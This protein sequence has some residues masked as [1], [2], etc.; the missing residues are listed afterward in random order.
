MHIADGILSL[1]VL[2]GGAVLAAAGTAY[3][4]SKIRSE[5]MPKAAC[6]SSAFFVASL[7]H[8]PIGPSSSHLIL[9]G[10]AGVILG[11]AAFPAILVALTLQAVL[12]QF[13]GFLS[14]GVNTLDMA[15]PAVVC[16]I[17][18]KSLLSRDCSQASAFAYGFG[19]GFLSVA[20]SSLLTSLALGLSD[21]AFST[22]AKLIFAAHVPV[23]LAEGVITGFTAS[24]L[25]R[26][27]P[28]TFIEP[29]CDLPME[30][31]T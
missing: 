31:E 15:L 12:F 26:L 9:N 17:L 2:G 7:I 29:Q 24:F 8:V 6:V 30:A 18:F 27:R 25:K 23:M 16:G 14:L 5:D 4:L 3:G 11:W 22:A 10:L 28:E 1:P 20:L 21:G 13:G 19:A